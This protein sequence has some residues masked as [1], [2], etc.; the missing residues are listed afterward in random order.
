MFNRNVLVYFA[1]E[2]KHGLSSKAFLA[3]LIIGC[4]ITESQIITTVIP[5]FQR[6]L[7][8][9]TDSGEYLISLYN[10][11][12]GNNG[13]SYQ[14]ALYY[15]VLPLL[16][17]IPC[18]LSLRADVASGCSSKIASELTVQKYLTVKC[19]IA[20]ILGALVGV[21]PLLLNF[22]SVSLF[23]PAI[24]P[25]PTTGVSTMHSSR[26]MA[27]IFFFQ[28]ML[29]IS[30]YLVL[31]AITS[32]LIASSSLIFSLIISNKILIVLAPFIVNNFF[33]FLAT[34]FLDPLTVYCPI[35]FLRP[36]QPIPANLIAIVIVLSGFF[37]AVVLF[38]AFIS[39]N[40]E[41]RSSMHKTGSPDANTKV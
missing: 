12:F 11:W 29:Y 20:A 37:V 41:K 31:T 26:F 6:W 10:N 7:A 21:I 30:F 34:N 33:Y 16:V 36:D 25:E 9:G 2:L 19:L 32:A 13:T 1:K 27:D 8:H 14:L 5:E 28:P 35:V 15:Q 38:V 17:C 22:Y 3:T 40:G 23:L 24:L 18:A 4:T 39:I